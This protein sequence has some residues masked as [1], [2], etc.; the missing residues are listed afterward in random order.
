MNSNSRGKRDKAKD[1]LERLASQTGG[2]VFYA[3]KTGELREAVGEVVKDLHTQLVVGFTPPQSPKGKA[4][5]KIEV[6]V[7]DAPGRGKLKVV[8][9]PEITLDGEGNT[10]GQKK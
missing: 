3:V 7:V 10:A 2:R 9:K 5:H 4:Q 1:F 6:K 8:T